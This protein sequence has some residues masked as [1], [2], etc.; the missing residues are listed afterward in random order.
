[1]HVVAWYSPQWK[2]IFNLWINYRQSDFFSLTETSCTYKYS[3]SFGLIQPPGYSVIHLARHD[4]RSG[5]LGLIYRGSYKAKQMKFEKC[6]SFEHQTSPLSCGTEQL[7]VT[8]DWSI[9]AILLSIQWTAQFSPS[10]KFKI[11]DSRRLQFSCQHQYWCGCKEIKIPS[12]PVSILFSMWI[13]PRTPLVIHWI[14]FY[15]AVIS[16]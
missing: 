11:C 10:W 13:Y 6:S 8:H 5:G 3:A 1:M 14:S 16:Q 12:S 9:L 2:G 15:P 4:R 7:V